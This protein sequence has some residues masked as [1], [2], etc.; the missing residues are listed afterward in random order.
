MIRPAGDGDLAAL[1]ELE[2]EAFGQGA[3]SAATLR[4]ELALADRIVLVDQRDGVLTGY[5]DVGVVADVADLHRVVVATAHRRHGVASG[6]VGAGGAAA[7]DRG[8]TRMLLEVAADNAPALALYARHDF[9]PI[10]RRRGYYGPG[11]DAL[12]LEASL[13]ASTP[14]PSR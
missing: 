13:P 8:A 10:A 4:E 11:R 9:E 12:V 7:T 6:L 14:E 3:W 5:V 2:R 1:L